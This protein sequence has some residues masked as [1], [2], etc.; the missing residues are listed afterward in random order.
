M[1]TYKFMP[2]ERITYLADSLLRCT[3]PAALNDPLEC[4]PIL[5][6]ED[7]HR[8]FDQFISIQRSALLHDMINE[9]TAGQAQWKAFEDNERRLREEL[10]ANPAKLRDFFFEHA[11]KNL[12][13]HIGI[14]SLTK[15]WD[16]ML[17][18][19][20]YAA[21]HQGFCVGFDSSHVFF[22]NPEGDPDITAIRDVEY[23]R[24]RI[25]VPLERGVAINFDVMFR[26]G[27]DWAY[28]QEQRMLFMLSGAKKT[29]PD[30]P[31]CICLFHVPHDAIA[32][33]VTGAHAS[34]QLEQ[35]IASFCSQRKIP[36]MRAEPSSEDFDMKRH[37][38]SRFGEGK[39]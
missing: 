21:S 2:P 36:T 9:R 4:I 5:S 13:E 25:K 26:K 35:E 28:E 10:E 11:K 1:L 32:E 6:I 16:S 29:I 33:V 24:E 12:N 39:S 27:L 19:S 3:Q 30:K 7:S 17:M 37:P 18:W 14:L 34:P 20:H 22:T 38:I 23:S 15:R 31:Y 8:V